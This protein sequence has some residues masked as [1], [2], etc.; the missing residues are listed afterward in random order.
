[1]E[2]KVGLYAEF[3]Q[4]AKEG[5]IY[6]LGNII[7]RS[8]N[9][10]LIPVLTRIFP[11]YDLGVINL[12]FAFQVLV[13]IILNFGLHASLSFFFLEQ[14]TMRRE[15]VSG[16]LHMG[17]IGSIVLLF[18]FAKVGFYLFPY[19]E[20]AVIYIVILISVFSS[21]LLTLVQVFRLTHRPIPFTGVSIFQSFFSGLLVIIVCGG[22][23]GSV[24]EYF[25]VN[26]LITFLA[27]IYAFVALKNY[28]Y[29]RVL[30]LSLY[31]RM[32]RFGLPIMFSELTSYLINFA[33]RWMIDKM[34]SK[35]VL[36]IYGIGVSIGVGFEVIISSFMIAFLPYSIETMRRYESNRDEVDKRLN[37]LWKLYSGASAILFVFSIFFAEVFFMFVQRSY[38]DG[39]YVTP[40]IVIKGILVGGMYFSYLGTWK[41]EKTYLYTVSTFAGGIA[42]ILLNL[43]LI[44]TLGMIGASLAAAL[45]MLISIS[46][47][48]LFSQRLWKINIDL[49][50]PFSHLIFSFF[51]SFFYMKLNF[52]IT[53]ILCLLWLAVSMF[54][55]FRKDEIMFVFEK[56]FLPVKFKK[57]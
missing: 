27:L 15:I 23:N 1:M 19:V 50:R 16:I 12:L 25:I 44:P 13:S 31:F 2:S 8:I 42:N 40:F 32:A 14:P 39:K 36:G 46:S 37:A 18:F 9:L 6:I 30:P 53:S 24:R 33:D 4:L 28:I 29:F 34:L 52:L 56:F 5:S 10:V 21:L 49:F 17:I 38:I 41:R 48:F 11:P 55:I 7:G 20:V 57:S 54:T 47:S 3:R 35:E 45:S 43:L 51:L 26:L 22:L